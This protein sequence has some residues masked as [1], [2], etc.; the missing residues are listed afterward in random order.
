[1]TAAD[2]DDLLA[3]V[4]D[5]TGFD[6]TTIAAGTSVLV[7][8]TPGVGVSSLVDACRSLAPDL[9]LIHI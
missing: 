2:A 5:L 9:S 1:M 7:T 3:R 8:G 6:A 4:A